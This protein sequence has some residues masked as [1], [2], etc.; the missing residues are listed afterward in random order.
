[1]VVLL[2]LLLLHASFTA[3]CSCFA[4]V[5]SPP[6]PPYDEAHAAQKEASVLLS[7]HRLLQCPRSASHLQQQLLY[8]A[9]FYSSSHQVGCHGPQQP[10]A[11]DPA[12]H[13]LIDLAL[14]QCQ[15]QNSVQQLLARQH[16]QHVQQQQQPCLRLLQDKRSSS[17]AT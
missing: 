2:V 10:A 14:P 4:Q 11:A 13:R 12:G 9:H 6:T 16:W 1:M 5:L 3:S 7:A 15:R 8:H 17:R